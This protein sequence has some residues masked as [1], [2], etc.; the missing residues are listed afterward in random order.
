MPELP[1]VETIKLQLEKYI[2]GHKI[3][4]IKIH[5]QNIFEGDRNKVL[6]AKIVS[7]RR[8]GK[9]LVVDL[10]NGYSIVIQIKLTGQLIYQGP[11]LP[12]FAKGY[13]G[14][15]KKVLGGLGGKHTHVIFE[16]DVLPAQKASARQ[17]AFLYYND[18][19][20]FGRIKVVKTEKVEETWS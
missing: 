12:H 11:K 8:F 19:R 16:L 15:S 18:V 14:L 5:W 4:N 17:G 9:V 7:V 2:V 3:T 6:G 20:K 1:E 10:N 13:A